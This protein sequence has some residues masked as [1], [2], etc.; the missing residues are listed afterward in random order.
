MSNW[1]AEPALRF[2]HKNYL[3]YP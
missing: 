2:V 3:G 1:R